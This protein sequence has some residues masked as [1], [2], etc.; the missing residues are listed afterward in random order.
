MRG[1]MTKL[2]DETTTPQF[3]LFNKYLQA[4]EINEDTM[5]RGM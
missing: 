1:G 4:E 3:V 2:Y 5:W